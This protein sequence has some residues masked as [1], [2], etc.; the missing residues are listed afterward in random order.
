MIWLTRN[1]TTEVSQLIELISPTFYLSG[2]LVAF[3]TVRI[4]VII[5]PVIFSINVEP[6]CKG[7]HIIALTQAEVNRLEHMPGSLTTSSV[8]EY[9][10]QKLVS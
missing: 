5:F 10:K 2:G 4:D 1:L 6:R 9:F 8:I 7:T 3:S